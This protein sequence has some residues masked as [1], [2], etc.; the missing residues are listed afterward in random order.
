MTTVSRTGAQRRVGAVF[1]PALLLAFVAG[2]SGAAEERPPAD[3]YRRIGLAMPWELSPEIADILARLPREREEK[4]KNETAMI[5]HELVNSDLFYN[6]S[7]FHFRTSATPLHIAAK[8]GDAAEAARLL[9]AGA[10]REARMLP[11]GLTPLA[12]AVRNLNF[13]VA[14]LLLERGCDPDAR[15][16]DGETPLMAAARRKNAPM[17]EL[18]LRHGADPSLTDGKGATAIRFA[19]A[20]SGEDA[21]EEACLA[22]VSVLLERGADPDC[23]GS[24][25][26]RGHPVPSALFSAAKNGMARLAEM[27]LE[28][29][30]ALDYADGEGW[31]PLLHAVWA[32]RWRT[33]ECFLERGATLDWNGRFTRRAVDETTPEIRVLLLRY[34]LFEPP[35]P[36][37]RAAAAGDVD[38]LD[39][40]LA[41]GADI[42]VA[43]VFGETALAHAAMN[44]RA[45]AVRLLIEHGALVDAADEHG[46]TPLLY[47]A[48]YGDMATLEPLLSA[49]ADVAA[50]DRQGDTAMHLAAIN[51]D[52]EAV[53]S[54]A[55][56]GAEVNRPGGPRSSSWSNKPS[57]ETAAMSPLH[58][59]A[60][61]GRFEAA[62]ALVAAGAAIDARDAA[63]RTPLFYAAEARNFDLLTFLVSAGA[64]VDVRDAW[65]AHSNLMRTAVA[66]GDPEMARFC[67]DHGVAVDAKDIYGDTALAYAARNGCD[68]EIMALLL[69]RGADINTRDAGEATPLHAL[70]GRTV[71]LFN[72]SHME[73]LLQNGADAN[74]KNKGGVT[75]LYLAVVFGNGR[76][77]KL[78]ADSGGSFGEGE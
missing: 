3:E 45:E 18:L 55:R 44:G 25:S 8:D 74:A 28:K 70:A 9:D 19:A 68:P 73:F 52:A 20:R 23:A 13:D 69:E 38:K 10:E 53:R 76:A 51:G 56:A 62:R 7:V 39:R 35:P 77:A 40:L 71:N 46:W 26:G 22:A 17:L 67:L 4:I 27:L 78:L 66:R 57:H 36:L 41:E 75:P 31:T 34:G 5:A 50:A 60:K 11:Y 12:A 59:A 58:W 64:D 49:G 24:G 14:E 72:R 15:D 33:A 63:K 37:L 32:R 48:R 65:G 42:G 30:A 47:A 2:T 54:L 43:G 1:L 21:G 6:E 16:D 61:Y 29:G